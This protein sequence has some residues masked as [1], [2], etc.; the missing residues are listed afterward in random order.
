MDLHINTLDDF[1][2][3]IKT[4]KKKYRR[5]RLF[6]YALSCVCVFFLFFIYETQ[7]CGSYS[8]I[9]SL[10]ASSLIFFGCREKKVDISRKDI[11]CFLEI[12]TRSDLLEK[13]EKCNL[14]PFDLIINTSSISEQDQNNWKDVFSDIFSDIKSYETKKTRRSFKVFFGLLIVLVLG[15]FYTKPQGDFSFLKSIFFR[16]FVSVEVEDLEKIESVSEDKKVGNQKY[17]LNPLFSKKIVLPPKNLV[18]INLYSSLISG[19]GV[20]LINAEDG[21]LYQTFQL[22][23]NNEK[24]VCSVTIS[25]SRNVY[26]KIPSYSGN[27]LALFITTSQQVPIVSLS[28]G[29]DGSDYVLDETSIP[30]DIEVKSKT[31]LDRIWLEFKSQKRSYEELVSQVLKTDTFSYSDKYPLILEQYMEEDMEEFEIQAVAQDRSIPHPLVGR[32]DPILIRVASSYGM[33]KKVLENLKSL[34]TKIEENILTKQTQDISSMMDDIYKKAMKLSFFD[35]WDRNRLTRINNEVRN[36]SNDSSKYGLLDDIDDFL[37]EHE[38]MDFRER[39]RDFFVATRI[40]STLIKERKNLDH[41]FERIISFLQEREKLWNLRV[42]KVRK[43]IFKIP[44]MWDRGVVKSFYDDIDKL[45]KLESIYDNPQY[46]SIL[47]ELT[48]RYKSWIEE[49]EAYEDEAEKAMDKK[50]EKSM[51]SFK[52]ELKKLQKQQ[53]D[54]SKDLDKANQP[55]RKIKISS[56]EAFIRLKQ[57]SNISGTKSLKMKMSSFMPKTKTRLDLAIDAMN[58]VVEKLDSKDYVTAESFSDLASRLLRDSESSAQREQRQSRGNRSRRKISSSNY[59]GQAIIGRDIEIIHRYTVDKKYRD[60][61]MED[62]QNEL[63]NSS[64]LDSETKSYLKNYLK[65]VVR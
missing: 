26:L 52:E 17:N 20:D 50:R 65:Q 58:Q 14:N 60:N 3:K 30:L 31:G 6:F 19:M 62:I 46:E 4:L 57:T 55:E 32:S 21:S 51:A 38:M 36:F 28:S 59:H 8:Y 25:I 49:L 42:Q 53:D 29:V 1:V 2:V 63:R 11:I 10:F 7:V 35:A 23:C 41:A 24:K 15:V 47:S 48:R 16:N 56:D 40:L 9:L 27:N 5:S 39:D 43:M 45:K 61:I 37:F 64:D 44:P 18:T 22:A 34:K 33:Y 13:I 54:I 12:S